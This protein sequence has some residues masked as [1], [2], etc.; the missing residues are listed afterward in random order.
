M[1][2]IKSQEEVG[3]GVQ[4]PHAYLKVIRVVLQFTIINFLQ[5][6]SFL[7]KHILQSIDDTNWHKDI[8]VIQLISSIT[9]YHTDYQGWMDDTNQAPFVTILWLN[10]VHPC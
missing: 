3:G 1:S 2:F 5:L 8:D 4:I 10:Y 7:L 6:L 9:F